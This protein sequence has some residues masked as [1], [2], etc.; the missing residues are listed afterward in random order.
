MLITYRNS[1]VKN[2]F[3]LYLKRASHLEVSSHVW[4]IFRNI[5]VLFFSIV[6]MIKYRFMS[7]DK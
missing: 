1:K 6:N 4:I 5:N 7:Y 3:F 2:H